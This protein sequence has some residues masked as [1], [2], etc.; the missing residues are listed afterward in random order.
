VAGIAWNA[1]GS[2][3]FN[4]L[5]NQLE[6]YLTAF[7][8]ATTYINLATLAYQTSSTPVAAVQADV[9]GHSMGGLI[10]RSM[11]YSPTF[12]RNTNYGRG[13]IHKLITLGTP[14]LGSHN[15][16]RLID[17]TNECVRNHAPL[18]GLMSESPS[19]ALASLVISGTAVNGA[20]ADLAGDGT[21]AGSSPFI[22]S[23]QAPTPG[24]SDRIPMAM[25]A[26]MASASQFGG[27]DG[28]ATQ[29]LTQA[30]CGPNV[31]IGFSGNFLANNFSGSRWPLVFGGLPSDAVVSV[32]SALNGSKEMNACG[33]QTGSTCVLNPSVHGPGTVVELGFLPPHLQSPESGAPAA[34]LD[35]LN[36]SVAQSA[37]FV[38]VP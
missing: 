38:I 19:Y 12:S 15:A 24:R 9:V 8:Q 33:S 32:G 29:G 22:R 5:Q 13:L 25:I 10:A 30:T 31:D 2:N 14:H 1:Y 16:L 3:N 4:N 18:S 23:I 7:K 26:G 17:G 36:T 20:V 37:R 27:I 6:G 34:V 21:V 28:S 35:L 11:W